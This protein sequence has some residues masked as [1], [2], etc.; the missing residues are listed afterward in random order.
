MDWIS[1][2]KAFH[3]ISFVAWFAGLFYLWRLFVYH[4]EADDMP[5]GEG[6]VLKKQFS[7]MEMRVYKAIINPAMIATWLFGGTML[8]IYGLEWLRLNPW[9]HIKLTLLV[10]L[11]GY[12]GFAGSVIKKFAAGTNKMSSFKLRLFN[13]VPTLFLLLIVLLASVK[14]TSEFGK[15]FGIV[16]VLGLVIFFITKMLKNKREAN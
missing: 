10:F 15:I 12:T 7:L 9:M 1:Y 4:R 8:F 13:E 16:F 14:N 6:A 11:S 2:L 3:I 5:A